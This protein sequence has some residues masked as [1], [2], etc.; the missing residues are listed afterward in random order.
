MSYYDIYEKAIYS[1]DVNIDQFAALLSIDAE[2][3][4]EEMAHRSHELTMKYFGRTIQLY[5]PLY[6]SNYCDNGCVYCGFNSTNKIERR[7]LSL[8]EVE[9]EA[10]VISSG[11][12]KHILLLTGESRS[13]SPISYIKD[14]V[15]LLREFFSSISIEVYALT[16]DEYV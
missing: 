2:A 5:T 3:H 15:K 8:Y 14:C 11:G 1:D 12:L 13:E 4:L 9:V 6:L 7:K 10:R 16:K